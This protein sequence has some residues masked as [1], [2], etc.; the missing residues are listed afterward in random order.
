M[1]ASVRLVAVTSVLV[2][3]FAGCGDPGEH[4]GYCTDGKCDEDVISTCDTGGKIVDMSGGEPRTNLASSL[5][6]GFARYVMR[7][8]GSC[9][10]SFPDIMPKLRKLAAPDCGGEEGDDADVETVF[11][12]EISHLTQTP[13]HYRSVT[14]LECNDDQV[15]FS[16]FGISAGAT[17]LPSNV[18]I[19]SFDAIDG[20]FNYYEADG[21]N[22]SFFGNSKDLLKGSPDQKIRRCAQC[23]AGG[24]LVMKELRSPWLHWEGDDNLPGTDE[25]IAAHE[26]LLGDEM[27]AETL[28]DTITPANSGWNER[29]ITHLL[30]NQ[31]RSIQKLLEPLF[32]PVEINIDTGTSSPRPTMPGD[33]DGEVLDHIGLEFLLD[34]KLDFDALSGVDI[35]PAD[36]D[37]AIEASGQQIRNAQGRQVGMHVDTRFDFPFV[38]RSKIDQDYVDQ[39]PSRNLVDSDFIKDVLSVDFTRPVFSNDRCGLLKFAPELTDTITPAKIREGFIAKLQAAA[40]APGTPAAVLLTN[41]NTPGDTSAHDAKF[42]AF[43]KACQNLGSTKLVQNAVAI[44]SLARN[45]A[46]ELP[47]LEFA[48]TLPFDNLKTDRHARLHPTTCE[49]V[50]HFVDP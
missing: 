30:T 50:N 5:N 12:S 33:D 8:G 38:T 1:P 16:L 36:Y 49:L 26:A 27:D 29:R 15:F 19:I 4:G 25:L 9:P 13:S 32:C 10:T 3:A 34:R 7:R 42:E 11:V 18:E 21:T 2:S 47:I 43:A 44:A 35:N 23:H 41:L 48:E 46:R 31:P 37:A 24:G 39:L 22:I 6:D 14:K 28:E 40:P 20:V 45:M 17:A